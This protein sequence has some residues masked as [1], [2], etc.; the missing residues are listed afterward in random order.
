[1]LQSSIENVNLQRFQRVSPHSFE[2]GHPGAADMSESATTAVQ[3]P[4]L[5]IVR[6]SSDY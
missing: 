6:V 2:S 5:S 4:D 3:L 1:M